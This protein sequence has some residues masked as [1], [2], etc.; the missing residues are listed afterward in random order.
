MLQPVAVQLFRTPV[1]TE[2]A[3]RSTMCPALQP[4]ERVSSPP[5]DATVTR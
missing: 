4:L 5:P 1:N 2:G 3:L